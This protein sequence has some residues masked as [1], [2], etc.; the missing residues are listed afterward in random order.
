MPRRAIK[1]TG[2]GRRLRYGGRKSLV[3]VLLAAIGFLLYVGDRQGVFGTKPAPDYEKYHDQHFRV[4]RVVDGDTIDLD[5]SDGGR[6]HTR[7][8]L[9]GVDTP[10]TVKPNTPPQHYGKQASQE[11]ARLT[12]DKTVRLGLLAS[13]SPT[14]TRDKYGRLLAY[15]YLEDRQMLNRV[16]VEQGF[17]YADPRFP[18]PHKEEFQALQDQ[19]RRE[20]RG[21]WRDVKESDLP[22]YWRGKIHLAN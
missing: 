6:S 4:V 14:S 7:V 2:L 12:L 13:R 11:T 19:A 10:E 9:W 16:L 21:L 17:A 20:R 22:Y 5:V 3:I 8:R 15:I 1:L 18:H